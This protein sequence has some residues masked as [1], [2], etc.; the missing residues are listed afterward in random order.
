MPHVAY[1]S[2][3]SL[4]RFGLAAGEVGV[5]LWVAKGKTNPEIGTILGLSLGTVCRHTEHIFSKL[6]VE[7]RTAA[8]RRA[9]EAM[10]ESVSAS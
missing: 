6:G 4:Q 7:T 10:G 3:D 9:Y 5:L 1:F 2:A 8:A